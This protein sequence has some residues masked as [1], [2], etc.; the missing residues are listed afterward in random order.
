MCVGYTELGNGTR[1]T[2]RGCH[3]DILIANGE[4]L[5]KWDGSL[6]SLETWDLGRLIFMSALSLAYLSRLLAWSQT[7]FSSL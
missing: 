7:V 6:S 5:K 2:A 4:D 3:G 1:P